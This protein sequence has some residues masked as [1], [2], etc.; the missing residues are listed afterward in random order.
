MAIYKEYNHT[1]RITGENRNDEVINLEFQSYDKSVAKLVLD[2]YSENGLPINLTGANVHFLLVIDENQT[3]EILGK[4]EDLPAGKVSME[5]PQQIK[6]Y[7]GRVK[8]GVYIDFSDGSKI[9]V[10]N[11]VFDLEKSLIDNI[12]YTPIKGNL[13]Q[14]FDLALTE[15]KNYMNNVKQDTVNYADAQKSAMLA[16]TNE[17]KAYGD[18]QKTQIGQILP[19]VQSKVAAINTELAKIDENMPDLFVA[20]ADDINGGGFS[21]TNN[22]KLYKGFG[23]KNSNLPADY[24]WEINSTGLKTVGDNLIV[25]GYGE[26]KDNT[27]FN[28][29]VFDSTNSFNN[30]PS[31]KLNFKSTIKVGDGQI[32]VDIN[33]AYEFS[34]NLKSDNGG[35]LYLGWDEY[36]I[37][38]KYI[39]PT[40][41]MGFSQ[42]TTTLARDLNDGDT[43][44][45]LDS[46]ANWVDSNFM[47]Q[48]GLIFWNYRDS[49]GY[50]Y[51]EGVYSRNAWTDLYTK[52]NVNKTNNTIT[53]KSPWNYGTI[54]AGTRV[55]QSSSSGHKYRNFL[56]ISI[57]TTW[58]NTS[59]RI[60][61]DNQL[62]APYSLDSR[63]FN[64]A[65]KSISFIFV[66]PAGEKFDNFYINSIE[67]KDI[68]N[69]LMLLNA[70]PINSILTTLSQENPSTTLG[71]T[72]TQLGSE[73][74]FNQTIYY[75]KRTN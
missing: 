67:L 20:Y 25:N 33:K 6:G 43:V 42:T 7:N 68:D 5:I 32:L 53:L 35:K 17:V 4:I 44:V 15:I 70:N 1:I 39:F 66:L 10:R 37:D 26:F 14:T 36:D 2:L 58:T 50:L 48:N 52:E 65:A 49:T 46:T 55:S 47:H 28:D 9:D 34:M 40:S 74:K 59:F 60:G 41:A 38:G 73:T 64:P 21:K 22:T 69:E 3:I 54:T 19:D 30:R 27:N 18:N 29:C 61:E 71:G 45:Y 16:K 24:R 56:G 75:W 13:F 72:W 31:F 62:Q 51:P 63:R 23:V 11:L 8:C 57:P 12:D